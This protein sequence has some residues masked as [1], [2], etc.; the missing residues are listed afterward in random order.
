MATG[1]KKGTLMQQDVGAAGGVAPL[2]EDKKVPA[3]N[4]P[5]MDYEKSGS[6]KT[7]N[8][9]TDAHGALFAKKADL[10][11]GSTVAFSVGYDAGGLYVVTE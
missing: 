5:E 2:G 8:E 3:E 10:D 4:L 11:D 1:D 6:V 7:H 9:A